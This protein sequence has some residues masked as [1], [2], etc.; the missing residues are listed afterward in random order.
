M[1]QDRFIE[2]MSGFVDRH[3]DAV[4]LCYLRFPQYSLTWNWVEH[5]H[6]FQYIMVTDGRR[7][8]AERNKKKSYCGDDRRKKGRFCTNCSTISPTSPLLKINKKTLENTTKI[9]WMLNLIKDNEELKTKDKCSE[10]EWSEKARRT[11]VTKW[12]RL[13]KWVNKM[14]KL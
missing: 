14:A 7:V 4:M 12:T 8:G 9:N 2:V 13:I 3:G 6:R 11:K 1:I 5:H 10:M